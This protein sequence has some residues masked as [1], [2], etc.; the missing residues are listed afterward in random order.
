MQ[1]SDM[2]ITSDL[3]SFYTMNLKQIAYLRL[4]NQQIAGTKFKTAKEIV[5]W[6]G[7]V[8]A[9]DY[10][11]AKWAIGIR[12]PGS[13]EKEIEYA[14][15]RGEILRTHLLR[16]TWHFVS[17][18]D[19][20]WMLQLTAPH[21][22]N[23]LKSRWKQLELDQKTI[24]KSNRIIEKA[25]KDGKHLT[26]EE[27]FEILEREKIAAGN[28]RGVHLL[29]EAE[30]NGII[31]SGA[32]KGNQRTYALLEE[33][34]PKKNLLR[35]DEALAKLAQKYFSSHGPATLQDFVW[36]S[37]LPVKDARHA[38][39]MIKQNF[40]S[41][42]IGAQIYW[43]IN[44]SAAQT[45]N[46]DAAYLL[47]AYDEYLISYKDRSAVL[48]FEERKRTI[49]INGIFKPTV[50]ANGIVMGIWRKVTKREKIIMETDFFQEIN[51]SLQTTIK[52]KSAELGNFF[53]KE[54]QL[55]VK[56]K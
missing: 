12:L 18:D 44:S 33:R 22:K 10:Q 25:L 45:K 5:S 19:I 56:V 49:S 17:S 28:Q 26:R 46:K 50:I 53:K 40:N 51:K 8:Q 23:S 30:L 47:P 6:M 32:T 34:V 16:P 52:L 48:A 9:Q 2:N 36:W 11:M 38:I 1:V 35:R 13:I 41:Q 24:Q 15:D 20:Y 39:E 21:I 7:A 54:V 31:C 55:S 3:K 37:G 4:I 14:V 29:L 27:I 42:K 43:S